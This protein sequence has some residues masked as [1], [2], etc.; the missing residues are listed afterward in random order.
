[1]STI[2]AKISK[3]TKYK[4][5]I[6]GVLRELLPEDFGVYDSLDEITADLL[7]CVVISF[8]KG[9]R[10]ESLASKLYD[11]KA[12]MTVDMFLPLSEESLMSGSDNLSEILTC[13]LINDEK[14]RQICPF[15][16]IHEISAQNL[17]GEHRMRIVMHD[18][19]L[20]FLWTPEYDS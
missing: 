8:D 12:Q 11:A 1:M 7:P 19:L 15:I 9:V 16:D 2:L 20:S 5:T 4:K 17:P 3:L 14:I 13:G 10:F 18:F 6:A